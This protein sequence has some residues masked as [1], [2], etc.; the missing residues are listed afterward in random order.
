M[1]AATD[2]ELRA[3][4]FVNLRVPQGASREEFAKEMGRR[5]EGRAMALKISQADLARAVGVSRD[6]TN[7]WWHGG[8]MPRRPMLE[9]IARVLDTTVEE[10]MP[11]EV[12]AAS[13]PAGAPDFNLQFIGGGRCRVR[14]DRVLPVGVGTKIADMVAAVDS[15]NADK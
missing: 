7:K 4:S 13:E 1:I 8:S 3:M 15:G 10:L 5:I 6:S 11:S 14:M 12:A 2:Q 9:K